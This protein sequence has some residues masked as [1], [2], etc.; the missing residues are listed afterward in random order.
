MIFLK[1]QE[2]IELLRE[3]NRL[4]GMTLGEVSKH[5]RPGISTLELDG[6][7]ENFIRTHGACPGFLGYHGFPGT[8]CISINDEVVH[9]IPSSRCLKEGD[10]V[11]VDCVVLK[12]GFYGD[13]AYTFGVGKVDE[14]VKELLRVTRDCLYRGIEQAVAG[15]RIGDVGFAIQSFA[16]S[17]GFSVVRELGGRGVGRDLH[18]DPQLPNYG[19]QGVGC[20]L[21]QGMVIAIEP[22]I[23]MGEHGVYQM[24]DGW[25]ICKC[26]HLPAAHF[27]HVVAIGRGKA[28]VLSTFEFVEDNLLN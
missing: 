6:I 23:S 7:A 22:M 28:D 3:S 5:I 19:R 8:L 9:G 1:T 4:V 25:T 26:D 18:E 11:S 2:E 15:M 27:E 21:K 13:G 16:E 17:N 12:N 20:K 24:N 10:I 14:K